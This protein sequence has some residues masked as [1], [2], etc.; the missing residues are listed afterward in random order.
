MNKNIPLQLHKQFHQK[1]V[2][3][4][5]SLNKVNHSFSFCCSNFKLNKQHRLQ[6]YRNRNNRHY[7]PFRLMWFNATNS[8]SIVCFYMFLYA[9]AHTCIHFSITRSG[10][11]Q[12]IQVVKSVQWTRLCKDEIE[13]VVKK[14]FAFQSRSRRS[15]VKEVSVN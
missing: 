11:A 7:R 3:A 10:L 12:F 5:F 1:N 8:H 14:M 15:K 13:N 6:C 2:F 9:H 4:Y